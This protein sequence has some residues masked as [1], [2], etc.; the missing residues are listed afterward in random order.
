MGAINIIIFSVV[1]ASTNKEIADDQCF[2]FTLANPF[3]TEPIKITPK[4]GV[5]TGIRCGAVL[6]P[7]FIEKENALGVDESGGNLIGFET[8]SSS[9]MCPQNANHQTFFL[10]QHTFN[11][12]ELEVFKVDF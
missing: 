3:G 7:R 8:L 1:L 9:F 11:V 4:R 2:L 10:G 6:G 5:T 12:T